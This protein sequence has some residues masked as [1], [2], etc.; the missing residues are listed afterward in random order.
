MH[1]T[2]MYF[3]AT[4]RLAATAR[5][6]ILVLGHVVC[7]AFV[8]YMFVN[9]HL[10]SILVTEISLYFVMDKLW[11][12][13]LRTKRHQ[14]SRITAKLTRD[15]TTTTPRVSKSAPPLWQH[16]VCTWI[17]NHTGCYIWNAVVYPCPKETAEP[18]LNL[19][20][21]RIIISNLFNV[22]VFTHLYHCLNVTSNDFW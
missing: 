7:N 14:F 4:C 3:S 5:A 20:L 11:Q 16:I 6:T 22:D 15:P 19:G 8:V 18:R 2:G 17:S 10:G 1:K 9:K 13:K 12:L 21:G